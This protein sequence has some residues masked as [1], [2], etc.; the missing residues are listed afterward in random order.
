MIGCF[1]GTALST[2]TAGHF[3]SDHRIYKLHW[4]KVGVSLNL[5]R[6]PYLHFDRIIS[7]RAFRGI[8]EWVHEF[9]LKR[10]RRGRVR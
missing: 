8:V 6:E 5:R 7:I 3:L 10:P 4:M 2:E 9:R 1:N